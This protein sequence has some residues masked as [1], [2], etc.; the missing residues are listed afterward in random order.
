MPLSLGEVQN[1][2]PALKRPV[3]LF[4]AIK[5][6]RWA[7]ASAATAGVSYERIADLRLAAELLDGVRG[8][9]GLPVKRKD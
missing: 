3:D 9:L 6:V 1:V 7:A 8:K 4:R 5:A 2:V